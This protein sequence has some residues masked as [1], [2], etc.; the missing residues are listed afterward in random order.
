MFLQL[1]ALL[2]ITGTLKPLVYTLNINNISNE[3]SAG[4]DHHCLACTLN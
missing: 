2:F 4:L 1:I 3:T